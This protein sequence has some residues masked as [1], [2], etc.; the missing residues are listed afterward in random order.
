[1]N[2]NWSRPHRQQPPSNPRINLTCHSRTH[3]PSQPGFD[4]S[5]LSSSPSFPDTR[6]RSILHIHAGAPENHHPAPAMVHLAVTI[7]SSTSANQN[8]QGIVGDDDFLCP[9]GT[10]CYSSLVTKLTYHDH[11][12]FLG[13]CSTEL[14]PVAML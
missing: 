13:V 1:M 11:A 4:S 6:T 12:P 2:S 3:S 5:S 14:L 8:P 9:S 10:G 7:P